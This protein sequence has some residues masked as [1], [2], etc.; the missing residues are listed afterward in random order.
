MRAMVC[1]SATQAELRDLPVIAL[2]AGVM[3][4]ERE[5]ALAAGVTGFLA[6]PLSLE[7]MVAMLRAY[8]PS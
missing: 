4:E 7:T 6:K 5:R 3:A 8:L 1:G 2:T